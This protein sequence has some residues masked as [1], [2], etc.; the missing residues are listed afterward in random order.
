[1]KSDER[2][3]YI[4]K[5]LQENAESISANS[6]ATFFNVTRQIIVSDIAI[7]RASGYSISS[8]NRGYRLNIINNNL[9][10]K[11]VVNHSKDEVNDE[12]YTIVDNGGKIINVIVDHPIYGNISAEL[13][14]F[15]RYDVDN[16]INR[17]Y[18]TNSNPLSFLT[19]GVHI[20][21]IE[22]IDDKSFERIKNKLNELGI[23]I[24]D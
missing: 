19:Q 20:H 18:E 13:N 24:S 2:R 7:L 12:L 4:I 11:L 5:M 1:M 15:S 23:L 6:L 8:D 14:L 10:K 22:V 16:F 9:V 17:L 3:N 21:T